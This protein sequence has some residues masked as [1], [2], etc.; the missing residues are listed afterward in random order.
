MPGL[1]FVV[2]KYKLLHKFI[3]AHLVTSTMPAP[4]GAT[5]LLAPTSLWLLVE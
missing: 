2:K 4:I 5:G 3:E 1:F